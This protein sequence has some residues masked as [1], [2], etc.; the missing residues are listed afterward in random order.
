MTTPH[1]KWTTMLGIAAVIAFA[2]GHTQA[3]PV[4]EKPKIVV[5]DSW[6]YKGKIMPDGTPNDST[7]TVVEIDR[8]DV[9]KIRQQTGTVTEYDGAMNWMPGGQK[10]TARVLVRY[11]LKVGD[12]WQLTRKFPNSTAV[13]DIKGKVVAYEPLT[14]PAGT[15]QCYRVEATTVLT[16]G[17]HKETR[18]WKRWYCP[19]VKS[20][21]K[22]S[23]DTTIVSP[24]KPSASGTKVLTSELVKFTPGK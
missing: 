7:R 14:V 23:I 19:E 17:P 5:G 6:D 24:G 8:N 18:V 1:R 15:F 20:Y 16:S 2:A 4:A 21:A 22:E 11:P 3:Q 9:L 12:E 13:E 10:D